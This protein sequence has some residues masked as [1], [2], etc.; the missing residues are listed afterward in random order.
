[1]RGLS[2]AGRGARAPALAARLRRGSLRRRR[3]RAAPARRWRRGAGAHRR[4]RDCRLRAAPRSACRG[5]RRARASRVADVRGRGPRPRPTAQTILDALGVRRGTPILGGR[6]GARQGSSSKRCP[7]SARPSIERRLPDTIYRP[8]GR[9]RAAGAVAARR[10]DRAD[11][12]R[13]RGHPGR[14]GSTALP[15][16]RWW[17]ATTP[18]RM[19][20]RIAG[21]AGERARS[22]RACHRRGAGRRPALEP[23]A[24][25]TR[26][27]CCCRRRTR[28]PPGHRLAAL[29]RSDRAPRARRAGGRSCACRTG[30]SC[31]R[32]GA[33]QRS[34]A[35][36][37]GRPSAKNT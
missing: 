19:R 11:R 10:Q 33:A 24:S 13:R 18:P 16:C 9:A 21:D 23:A 3:G 2:R 27:T 28:P 26:S 30:W 34:P 15:R 35:S 1:M 12:P 22:R 5:E 17:S 25:T 6:P 37:E 4:P 36:Q 32:A 8:P 7:G 31:G 20:R 14:P 29:E